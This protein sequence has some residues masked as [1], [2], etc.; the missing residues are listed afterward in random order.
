MHIMSDAPS[1]VDFEESE[2]Q[3]DQD[4]AD[5]FEKKLN[6]M[7]GH[8]QQR[9]QATSNSSTATVIQHPRA[10]SGPLAAPPSASRLLFP[11][12]SQTHSPFDLDELTP[13]LGA[14]STG[15]FRNWA[16][17]S[18]EAIG[19]SPAESGESGETNTSGEVFNEPW[20]DEE[21]S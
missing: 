21:I 12:E 3:K 17:L 16:A 13:I 10:A 18:P 14:D 9:Y 7:D 1:G 8:A 6:V 5:M 19:V 15:R 11:A 20:M 2:N 4:L